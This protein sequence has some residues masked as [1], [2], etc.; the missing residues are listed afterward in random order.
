MARQFGDQPR[1]TRD[2]T[3]QGPDVSRNLDAVN[4][5]PGA[6]Q[7][8]KVAPT[9]ADLLEDGRTASLGSWPSGS[10]IAWGRVRFAGPCSPTIRLAVGIAPIARTRMRP[11][12]RR[13][14]SSG[15]SVAYRRY[16]ELKARSYS[17]GSPGTNTLQQKSARIPVAYQSVQN[18]PSAEL[19]PR[20]DRTRSFQPIKARMS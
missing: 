14:S 4:R 8:R 9:L 7:D 10:P 2:P 6:E 16:T 3:H 17:G 12:R 20:Y 19:S 1:G 18:V 13:Q 5:R 11:S 15:I